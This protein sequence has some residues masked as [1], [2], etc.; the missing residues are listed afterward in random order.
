MPTLL[1]WLITGI[2][3]LVG[4]VGTVVPGLPGITLI[5]AGILL[6]AVATGFDHLSRTTVV[7]M[8]LGTALTLTAS[9]VGSAAGSRLGGGKKWAIAGTFIGA[10]IGAITSGPAGLFIGAFLGAL[11]GALCEGRQGVDAAKIAAF[12]VLGI[13]GATIVQ[14]FL[15]VILILAFFFALLV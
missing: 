7:I 8:G 14:F 9:Y 1:L 5:Y 4:L 12:S 15:G 6:Y 13:L 3:F 10:L 2:L 11:L